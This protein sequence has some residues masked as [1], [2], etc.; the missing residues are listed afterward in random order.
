MDIGEQH[1]RPR[2]SEADSPPSGGIFLPG[3]GDAVAPFA[4]PS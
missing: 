4:P 2:P 1:Y 3:H